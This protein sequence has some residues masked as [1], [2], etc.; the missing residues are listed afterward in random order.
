MYECLLYVSDVQLFMC[1][2][3]RVCVCGCVCECVI[4]VRYLDVITKETG[5]LYV[6]RDSVARRFVEFLHVVWAQF[7]LRRAASAISWPG[8]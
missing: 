4:S 5:L 7:L 3:S 6:A 1:Y 8:L 2:M